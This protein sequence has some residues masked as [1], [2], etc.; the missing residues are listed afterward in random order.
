MPKVFAGE[1]LSSEPAFLDIIPKI[2]DGTRPDL[3][4]RAEEQGLTN[5]LWD[6][7]LRCFHQDP[8]QQPNMTE[9]VGLLR[10]LLMPP[11]RE[12]LMPPPREMPMP[13]LFVEAD[14][15]DFLEVCK[16]RG[17]D[18]QE[19]KAREF[20]DKLDEVRHT[21]RHGVNSSHH[22]S[23]HLTTWIFPRTN[24]SNI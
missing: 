10:E 7:T 22:R 4:Q 18:G 23:R 16:T 9:V 5:S 6:M 13:P 8:A 2:K 14:L 11:P 1:P 24:E 12:L 20:A 3:P 19:V 15:C 17:R 21:E